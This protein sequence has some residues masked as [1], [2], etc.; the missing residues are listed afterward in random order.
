MTELADSVKTLVARMGSHPEEFYGEAGKW[1]FIFKEKFREVLNEAEKGA[2]HEALR[3]VRRQ[4][5]G[6]EVITA[7]VID[8][9]QIAQIQGQYAEAEYYKGQLTQA[10]SAQQVPRREFY[11]NKK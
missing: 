9:V 2:I 7:L 3:V 10:K 4:E 6:A 1:K 5:F 8:D 11:T